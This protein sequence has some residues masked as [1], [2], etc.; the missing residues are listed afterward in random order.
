MQIEVG[1]SYTA[2]TTVNKSNTAK[3]VGSGS[4]DVFAT[5]MLV[6]L[7][8]EA[9]AKCIEDVLDT[10]QTSVGTHI[11]ISHS[12]ATPIGMQV[13]AVATV[14]A[15]DRRR[16]EFET[17]ASDASGEIGRG[18]HTRFIVDTERF[19]EKAYGKLQK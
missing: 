19:T 16:V 9:A 7:L 8:E 6:A 17:V 18:L 4:V 11:A 14:T 5:P 1:T 15:V 2:T 3:A 13:T 10:G 12:G